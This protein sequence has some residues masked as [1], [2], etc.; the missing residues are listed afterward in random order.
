[1]SDSQACH[2]NGDDLEIDLAQHIVMYFSL[3][4]T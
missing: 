1:M 2:K 4:Q 3:T